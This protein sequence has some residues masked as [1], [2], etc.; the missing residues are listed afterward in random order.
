[1]STWILLR[2]LT[3]EGRHWGDFPR[4]LLEEM[5]DIRAVALDLPGSGEHHDLP[6]PT[7]LHD[8]A[9]QCRLDLRRLGLAPPYRVL[10]MSMGAM[11]AA[12][13][14]EQHPHELEACVMI[15]TS[16]GAFSPL[17]HRM[18]PRAWPRILRLLL[19]S[20]TRRERFIFDLTSNLGEPP[21]QLIEAWT[22]I[23][24]SRPVSLRNALRQ[25]IAAARFRAPS[26][27]P[28]PTL[29]LASASDG[30]VDA[31]CSRE[32]AR[33]WSCPI[34]VHPSAGHDLPLDDGPWVARQIREWLEAKGK[35]L[36][37]QISRIHTDS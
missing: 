31:R 17:H 24:G 25:T 30:L 28:V 2:G 13:W 3:R 7:S 22:A 16:F 8:M 12:A 15:N 10:A 4:Q 37:P 23:R 26:S 18:R 27:I 32:I 36:D 29:I 35:G 34:A 21:P 11:V 14:A 5:P 9:Q 33:R 19:S 1:M 20:G 6:S